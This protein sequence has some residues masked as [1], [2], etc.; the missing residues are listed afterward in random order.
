MVDLI[1]E[2]GLRQWTIGKVGRKK[3]INAAVPTGASGT[4]D[5]FNA[6]KVA[7]PRAKSSSTGSAMST[8]ALGAFQ[9]SAQRFPPLTS[10]EQNAYV[11]TYQALI[12]QIDDLNETGRAKSLA[13]A[14]ELEKQ[15]N[16]ILE[17][18]CASCWK[19]AYL[20]VCELAEKR[21]GKER[22][23][24]M[25]PDLVAEANIAMVHAVRNFDQVQIPKFHTYAG[26][27]VRNHTRAVLGKEGYMRLA[28]S[29]NRV[30]RMAATHGPE[31]ASKLGRQW[32]VDELRDLLEVECLKWSYDHLTDA[33]K[34]LPGPHRRKLAEAKLRKQGMLGALRDLEDILLIAQPFV[35]LDAPL[36]VDGSG[37][38]GD[39]VLVS[40]TESGPELV[41]RNELHTKISEALETL[42]DREQEIVRLRYGF[43]GD[44]AWT[45]A[46]IA[47]K[48]GISSERVRQI[49]RSA[50][51]KLASSG[52]KH[53]SLAEY[54]HS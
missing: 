15:A 39:T 3:V 6:P 26:N 34:L 12:T 41:A 44:E 36:G 1:V 33:Q 46:M 16:R 35:N 38:V 5:G 2:C 42:S 20:I 32:S 40:S 22:S 10:D 24:E 50:L 31:L 28:P 11:A 18:V 54:V 49:E 14:K 23:Y 53:G 52:D 4:T 30:K 13:K 47:S 21:F 19:L 48:H 29:W 43:G 37:S 51:V 17:H 45:Y 7:L 25:L 9:R 8:S 27:V